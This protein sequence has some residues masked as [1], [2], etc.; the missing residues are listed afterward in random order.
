[1]KKNI[2][3]VLLLFVLAVNAQQKENSLLVS[4]TGQFNSLFGRG[5]DF[6]PY[7]AWLHIQGDQSLFTMK[8]LHSNLEQ[9]NMMMVDLQIDS[10][11]TV[12]K[13]IESNSLLFE[14]LDLDHRSHYYADTL[15]PMTWVITDDK[16]NIN[17][18]RCI[19]AVTE[20]KGREYIAWYD[21]SVRVSNGPWKLGGLPGL[22]MEAYDK[23]EQWH[24]VVNMIS[25]EKDFDFSYHRGLMNK[26]IKGYAAYSANMKK[27][28]GA[29]EGMMSAQQTGDCLSCETKSTLKINTWEPIY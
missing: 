15:Y 5:E 1:M 6:R 27:L 7:Q 24:V 18:V 19:K 4:Y 21:S 26:P 9:N 23:E 14:F 3:V 16:K 22:I 11:F 17:G 12:Y 20:F 13:D 8:Q 2:L 25:E 29:I 28:V 10:L